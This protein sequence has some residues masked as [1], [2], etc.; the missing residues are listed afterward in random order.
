MTGG[1]TKSCGCLA[2]EKH[3]THNQSNT[4]LYN[5][6]TLM[7]KRCTNPNS[8]GYCYY[9]GRG[10]SYCKQWER[11]EPFYQ[12]AINNG[13]SDNLS[14]DRIDSDGNYEPSNCRW[15]DNTIQVNNRRNYGE[16]PYYGIVRDDTGYRAQIT[17][18]GK[19]KYLA[20]SVDDIEYLVNVRNEYIDKHHLPNK[21]NVYI[22]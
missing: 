10:I 6:W 4:R 21:K 19:K 3:R 2:T 14:I 8:A 17:V 20:H 13:Y 12:W 18:K 7:K 11:F 5:I 9:G 22:S 16:I 15:V 1:A